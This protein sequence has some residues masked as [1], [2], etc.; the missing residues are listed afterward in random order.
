[1]TEAAVREAFSHQAGWCHKLGSPF[2]GLLMEVLA[3]RLDTSTQVGQRILAWMGD[4][5][6]TGDLVPLR[7]AGA[8]HALVLRDAT[9]ELAAL[10]PPNALPTAD[11]LWAALSPILETQQDAIQPFLDNA[12]QTN[13][14]GRAGPLMVGLMIIAREARLPIALYEVGASAGLNLNLD[15]FSYDLGGVPAGDPTS[16]VR[17]APEWKGDPPLG[18]AVR[19]ASRRGVDLAPLSAENPA[20]REKLM[21]FVWADQTERLARLAAALDIAQTYPVRVD[22]GD[23]AEWVEETLSPEPVAAVTRVLYH[24][25]AFQYFPPATQARLSEH[26]RQVG[27]RA[28]VAGPFAWL[29]YESDPEFHGAMS[30]R[31]TLWPGGKER[32]LGIGHAHGAS[33][34]KL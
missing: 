13:E 20:D 8:L 7:L 1:M 28:T 12:P 6:P 25:V 15:K 5:G 33:F 18:G 16:G 17:V 23:A 26:I 3:A 34:K 22:Q 31:L 4:T 30:L 10:Y 27:A 19:I 2:T 11:A 14:V 21:A 9:P 29:R 32:V 24:T